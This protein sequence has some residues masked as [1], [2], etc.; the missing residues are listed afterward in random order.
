MKPS[1][2]TEATAPVTTRGVNLNSACPVRGPSTG[3]SDAGEQCKNTL[4]C[5]PT[6]AG[7]PFLHPSTCCYGSPS[8]LPL[9]PALCSITQLGSSSKPCLSNPQEH[10]QL[11]WHLA[12][13]QFPKF[14]LPTCPGQTEAWAGTI[15]VTGKL[16]SCHNEQRWGLYLPSCSYQ[17]EDRLCQVFFQSTSRS[18]KNTKEILT[19]KYFKHLN[20]LKTN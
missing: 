20:W 8:E 4:Y 15:K 14:L 19:K 3:F 1:S 11:R 17:T 2:L 6:Q 7:K 12:G 13:S 18:E 16:H 9:E 10:G 5:S